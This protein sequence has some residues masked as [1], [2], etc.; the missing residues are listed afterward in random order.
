MAKY[1]APP[2]L[3][4]P[5]QEAFDR[6]LKLAEMALDM[7]PLPPD[8]KEEEKEYSEFKK[9]IQIIKALAIGS[10]SYKEDK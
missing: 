2:P 3:F 5:L 7:Y 8:T 6:V 9:S 4:M 1:V 10:H